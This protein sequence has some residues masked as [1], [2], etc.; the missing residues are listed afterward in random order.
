MMNVV[1]GDVEALKNI[2]TIAVKLH[3][4]LNITIFNDLQNRTFSS[5]LSP[6]LKANCSVW[7]GWVGKSK[8]CS[9]VGDW[10]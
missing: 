1:T 8:E 2:F 3:A 5:P 6:S 7:L 9:C 10:I 4:E